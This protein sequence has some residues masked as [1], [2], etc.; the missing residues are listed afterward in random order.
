MNAAPSHIG[1]VKIS[2]ETRKTAK[3]C[4][5][6]SD[7]SADKW[8]GKISAEILKAGKQNLVGKVHW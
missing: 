2:S 4:S 1:I 7:L 5:N 8:R 6:G 3:L